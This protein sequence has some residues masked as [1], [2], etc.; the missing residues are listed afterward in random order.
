MKYNE[1]ILENMAEKINLVDY[2][3]DTCE[4]HKRGVN[5]YTLC[6]IHNEKTPSLCIFPDTN[7]WHCFGCG[8][9]GNIY[10]WIMQ[11]DNVGFYEAVNKVVNLTGTSPETIS[12]SGTVKI[13]KDLK[14][15]IKPDKE[16]KYE[17][18][19][20]DF[21]NDYINKYSEELP[22]S[23]I[24]EGILPEVMKRFNIRI[25]KESNRIVYPL[26]DEFGNY[27][28]AKGRSMLDDKTIKLLGIPK[29][30][31]LNKIGT[32]DFFC[33]IKENY[34][35]IKKANKVIV[36]EG[37]KSVMH[38]IPWGYDYGISSETNHLN[39][40]QIKILI[41]LGIKEVIIAYD[42]GVLI[43]DILPQIKMLR[44]F[45]KVSIIM[46]RWGLLDDKDSPCDKGKEVF[47]K[48]Y[49]KRNIL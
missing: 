9:G 38:V 43:K 4:L 10:D 13:Y 41:K 47:D 30:V 26:Y 27:I 34:D 20:F 29:Y 45:T 39:E 49:K 12:E 19:I 21:T 25:D 44:K 1:E 3:A 8:A 42:K 5:Y 36:F 48:L 37:I 46:D 18:Q 2:A 17:R 14:K 22:Q 32:V 35:N 11:Y 33:G 15:Y 24:D 6:F 40:N 28:A 23:W 7:S 16:L 31:S